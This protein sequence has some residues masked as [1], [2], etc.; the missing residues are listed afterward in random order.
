MISPLPPVP[1][2]MCLREDRS[3]ISAAGLGTQIAVVDQAEDSMFKMSTCGVGL[4]LA[5]LVGLACG[6]QPGL[7]GAGGSTG[8]GQG[9]AGSGG[10]TGGMIGAGGV[11]N[12]SIG[13]AS[14]GA[15]GTVGSGG[16]GTG[17]PGGASGTGGTSG[18]LPSTCPML[19]CAG[20]YLSNPDSCGC[21]VCAS[22][23][24]VDGGIAPDSRE[25]GAL[26]GTCS[27]LVLLGHSASV[28]G[29]AF[30][31]DGQFLA[32]AG[33]DHLGKIW[34][35][36]DGT[37]VVTLSGSSS[38]L[39]SVAYTPDGQTLVTGG[40]SATYNYGFVT[41]WLTDGT[42]LRTMSTAYTYSIAISP[43]GH[44]VASA[45]IDNTARLWSIDSGQLVHALSGHVSYVTAVAFSPDGQTLASAGWDTSTVR[46]WDVA[47]GTELQPLTDNNTA[48]TINGVAFSPDGSL[49]ASANVATGVEL[50]SLQ[51]HQTTQTI[52]A[53]SVYGLA[54]TPDGTSVVTAG[55]RV[56]LLSLSDGSLVNAWDENAS[57]VAVS[58][59]GSRIAVGEPQ[60]SLKIFCLH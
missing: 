46:L 39:T 45:N 42:L 49:L 50:W 2:S 14:S 57:A 40:G 32:S 36:S 44:T 24:A 51:S 7:N 15:A 55:P 38:P 60:G 48:T 31:P 8:E 21:S 3:T 27:D 5:G 52:A 37:L 4:V 12:A 28:G 22:S 26:S 23:P 17:G 13:G 11:R 9:I 1:I 43:D 18:C 30:S 54:I 29:V 16:I 41:V 59:D 20:G 56:L 10:S 58:P 34:R 53:D 35:V 6:G 33:A 25:T 47:S 19:V